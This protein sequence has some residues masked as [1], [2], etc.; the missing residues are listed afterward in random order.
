MTQTSIRIGHI[1]ID[2]MQR[3]SSPQ[4][5]VRHVEGMIANALSRPV[6]SPRVADLSLPLLRVTLQPRA[7]EADV[8]LAIAH[9]VRDALASPR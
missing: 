6:G 4:A 5:L 2:G 1:A 7:S 8:A 9:A 3:L